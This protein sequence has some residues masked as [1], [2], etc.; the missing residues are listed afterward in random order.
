MRR[1]ER[2][3]TNQK[4]IMAL[5]QSAHIIHIGIQTTDY[6]YVV[7]TNYGFE[8]VA[9]QLIIY[10]HGAPIGRKRDLIAK[11]P[12]VGFEID[13]GN[14]LMASDN[15]D[16]GRNS[17][18]YHSIIGT[19]NAEL[20]ADFVTKKHALQTILVHETGHTW[21]NIKDHDVDYVGIIKIIV[22]QYSVKAHHDPK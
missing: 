9:G 10:V 11:Q 21:A 19:G 22:S 17:F 14:H 2:E 4:E 13:D 20:V 18:A 1:K 3:V 7:P 6:P 15:G 5:L 8:F 12:K 16:P